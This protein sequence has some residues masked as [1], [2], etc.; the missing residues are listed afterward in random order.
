MVHKFKEIQKEG[1]KVY[2][3]I[4]DL[5]DEIDAEFDALPLHTKL[6]IKTKETVEDF[7]HKVRQSISFYFQR[8]KR[9]FDDSETWN[10]DSSLAK[11]ILPRL[12]RF[13]ELSD[14][15]PAELEEGEWDKIL[16]EMIWAFTF[17]AGEERWTTGVSE[18]DTKT[19]ARVQSALN[20]FAKYYTGLWW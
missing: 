20:N 16:D 3:K 8:R 13:K 9:G 18:D 6:W 15:F 5:F 1:F 12:K 14:G 2:E 11:I 19:W 10:L 17:L 7:K 4:E